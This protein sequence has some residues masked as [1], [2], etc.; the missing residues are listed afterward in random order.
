M[1]QRQ[2]VRIGII[3]T[4]GADLEGDILTSLCKGIF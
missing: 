1:I 2:G 3:G 4:I